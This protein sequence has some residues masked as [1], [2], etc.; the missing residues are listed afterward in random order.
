MNQN[1]IVLDSDSSDNRLRKQKKVDKHTSDK[2]TEIADV[3]CENVVL[4]RKT[5]RC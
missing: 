4:M 2:Q 5:R 3:K 1:L